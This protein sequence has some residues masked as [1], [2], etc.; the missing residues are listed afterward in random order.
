MQVDDVIVSDAKHDFESAQLLLK[1]DSMPNETSMKVCGETGSQTDPDSYSGFNSHNEKQKH[2]YDKNA[3]VVRK[4]SFLSSIMQVADKHTCTSRSSRPKSA[5]SRSVVVSGGSTTLPS[6]LNR[7]EVKLLTQKQHSNEKLGQK[8]NIEEG[9]RAALQYSAE[10]QNLHVKALS[11]PRDHK[12]ASLSAASLTSSELY[13]A[14]RQSSTIS[15][16]KCC[17]N[18]TFP[19]GDSRETEASTTVGKESYVFQNSE[20]V[21][22]TE[23][24]ETTN[25]C[26]CGIS[27]ESV[28]AGFTSSANYSGDGDGRKYNIV[29]EKDICISFQ[30]PQSQSI[31]VPDLS[32]AQSK[33]SGDTEVTFMLPHIVN[34]ETGRHRA[35]S[36]SNKRKSSFRLNVY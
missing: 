20:Q 35:A 16:P 4:S 32:A 27:G 17:P 34:E 25:N 33:S 22:K 14:N 3:E 2:V 19:S 8:E 28:H 36:F 13:Y 30:A 31:E 21:D 10:C 11:L 23:E 26:D 12:S 29:E 15:S 6:H 1:P 5:P 7:S 9:A 24:D 18:T